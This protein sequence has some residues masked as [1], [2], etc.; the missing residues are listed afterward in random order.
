MWPQELR[1]R[2]RP[3]VVQPGTPGVAPHHG[4]PPGRRS[5]AIV[6]APKPSRRG[7]TGAREG[8]RPPCPSRPASPAR[9]RQGAGTGPHRGTYATERQGDGDTTAGS[10]VQAESLE[11]AAPEILRAQAPPLEV[12]ALRHRDGAEVRQLVADAGKHEDRSGLGG[13][14]A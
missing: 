14:A 6:R 1:G 8:P 4:Q 3:G 5:R 7:S 10:P 9:T 2:L 13:E 11:A 12:R